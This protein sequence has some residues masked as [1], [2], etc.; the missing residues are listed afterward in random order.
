MMVLLSRSR[1]RSIDSGFFFYPFLSIFFI[2]F[3]L[4][5][6]ILGWLGI[7]L[8]NLCQVVFN[9]VILVL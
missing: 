4:Y 3:Q 7:R 1:V 6:L 8:Y 9:E 5:S 2:L